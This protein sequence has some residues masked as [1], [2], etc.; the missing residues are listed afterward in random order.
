MTQPFISVIVPIY[1]V[2]TYLKGCLDSLINQTESNFEAILVDDGSTDQSSKIADEYAKKDARFKVIHQENKG[3]SGARNSALKVATGTYVAFLDS[4]DYLHP[5]FLKIMGSTA[6]KERADM[7][8]CQLKHTNK[9]Y[10]YPF[11][12]I[13]LSNLKVQRF[14]KP[15]DA[16]LQNKELAS[17]VCVKL[18]RREAIKNLTF[19]EGIYFED[20]LFTTIEMTKIKSVAYINAPLYYYYANPQS[21]MRS[22]FNEKKVD[23]YV[24]I[25]F[26]L[27]Q[28]FKTN[29]PDYLKKVQTQIL[30]KRVKMC[31]NQA[32]RKQRS[33][34]QSQMLF[35]K[36]AEEFKVL[37]RAGIISFNGLKIH[38]KMALALLIHNNPK[39]AWVIMKYL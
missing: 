12:K 11:E 25:I 38:Q 5:D 34:Y 31:M 15:L 23:S 7:V 16:F 37:Y 19:K 33:I 21:I 32:I 22:S 8:V 35:V 29:M 1:N 30:N 14:Y 10:S 2:E 18:H 6:K 28:Y 39:A 4:D 26:E 36:M 13:N 3:L 27:Y 24:T 17:N 20:V 9:F